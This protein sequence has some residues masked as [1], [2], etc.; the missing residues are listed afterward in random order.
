MYNYCIV[1]MY[2]TLSNNIKCH[3][4]LFNQEDETCN[5]KINKR[6]FKGNDIS[7]SQKIF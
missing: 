6:Y 2:K 1:N 4:I 3:F 7:T 5:I